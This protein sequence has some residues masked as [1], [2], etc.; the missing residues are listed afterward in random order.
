VVF[1]DLP[2]KTVKHLRMFLVNLPIKTFKYLIF[3]ANL[4]IIKF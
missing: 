1:D 3:S 2:I 4:P